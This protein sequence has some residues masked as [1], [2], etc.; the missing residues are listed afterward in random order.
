MLE[1]HRIKRR[2]KRNHLLHE[3]GRTQR[4]TLASN[5]TQMKANIRKTEMR[6]KQNEDAQSSSIIVWCP[7]C[8]IQ[9]ETAPRD[10]PTPS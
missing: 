6:T 1:E 9:L 2:V 7:S 8:L 3:R 10:I 5:R 4:E